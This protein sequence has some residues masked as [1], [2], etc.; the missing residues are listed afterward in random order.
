M[1]SEVKLLINR[2]LFDC[3]M[4]CLL[5]IADE[6]LGLSLL[7]FLNVVRASND[8][9]RDSCPSNDLLSETDFIDEAV[10]LTDIDP[11]PYDDNNPN[12]DHGEQTN[13]V[14]HASSSAIISDEDHANVQNYQPHLPRFKWQHGLLKYQIE[15]INKRLW[16]TWPKGFKNREKIDRHVYNVSKWLGSHPEYVLLMLEGDELTWN[17]V[18]ITCMF[19]PNREK[20]VSAPRKRNRLLMTHPIWMASPLL[21]SKVEK[22]FTR[23]RGH[24]NGVSLQI[25]RSRLTEYADRFGPIQSPEPLLGDDGTSFQA[26]A[27]AIYS[28]GAPRGHRNVGASKTDLLHR[29]TSD[30]D[31]SAGPS[32]VTETPKTPRLKPE[33]PRYHSGESWMNT[34]TL[35][36]V[37]A[38][39]SAIRLHWR[40]RISD[41]ILTPAYL[42]ANQYLQQH[43]EILTRI[44][45]GDASAAYIVARMV[46]KP[47]YWKSNT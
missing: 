39:H 28:E 6:M 11:A 21:S 40:D 22:I 12:M 8:Y 15:Y 42:A 14:T 26:A 24:W 27:D 16:A 37:A 3:S 2:A 13:S 18:I 44:Q 25:V 41:R 17:K 20:K 9:L 19:D 34:M 43:E 32:T 31:P 38:I 30:G 47:R 36:D 46:I 45:Q 10:F 7:Y 33:N 23:L 4:V 35:E 29:N 5:H 1:Q